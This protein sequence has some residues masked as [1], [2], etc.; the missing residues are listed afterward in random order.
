MRICVILLLECIFLSGCAYYTAQTRADEISADLKKGVGSATKD[1][2]IRDWGSPINCATLSSGEIC[3]W[4][5]DTGDVTYK[6]PTH[7]V[8]DD[9]TG[10]V[11]AYGGNIISHSTWERVRIE[12]KDGIMIDFKVDVQH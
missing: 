3:E 2:I 4:R 1:D 5:A 12:F 8:K 11:H 10:N 6:T 7:Y 9:Y